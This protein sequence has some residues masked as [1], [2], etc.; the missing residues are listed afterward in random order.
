M[1][2]ILGALSV[3]VIYDLRAKENVSSIVFMSPLV[4]IT[5]HKIYM[6]ALQEIVIKVFLCN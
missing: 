1:S 6:I 2:D 3:Y 5:H 4:H